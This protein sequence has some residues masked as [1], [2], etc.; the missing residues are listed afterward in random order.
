MTDEPKYQPGSPNYYWA[1][2]GYTVVR[3]GWH[4][5]IVGPNGNEVLHDA[6]HEEELDWINEN[7]EQ[8]G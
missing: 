2:H 4:R 5:T 7:L 1:K 8:V 3:N 6:D